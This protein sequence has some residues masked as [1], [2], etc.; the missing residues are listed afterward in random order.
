[1]PRRGR[2]AWLVAVASAMVLTGGCG[3]TDGSAAGRVTPELTPHSGPVFATP[4]VP[5]YEGCYVSFD[6]DSVPADAPASAGTLSLWLAADPESMGGFTAIEVE[7]LDCAG[8]NRG[9]AREAGWA[10]VPV[11]VLRASLDVPTG[12]AVPVAEGRLPSGS[13]DRVFVAVPRAWGIAADGR[14]SAFEAHVEPIVQQFVMPDRGRIAVTMQL[15]SRA[16]PEGWDGGWNLFT[17]SAWVL[18]DE[19]LG[20]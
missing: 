12:A 13:Y 20:P 6:L 4:R 7:L 15:T 1:M 9:A 5:V 2:R 10:R 16:R 3:A 17:R 8:A 11:T 18:G 14:R 19:A